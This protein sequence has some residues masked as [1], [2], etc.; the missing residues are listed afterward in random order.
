MA[1]AADPGVLIADEPTTALDV[2]IQ[3]QLL[4]LLKRRQAERHMALILITHDL[5]VVAGTCDRV[6]VMY[7]G[8]IVEE[9]STETVLSSP[10]HPYT[11]GL[12]RSVP[13]LD[14]QVLDRLPSIAGAPPLPG[15]LP[16]GCPF[17]PRCRFAFERCQ[18]D[19][20]LR[21][22]DVEGQAAACWADLRG[23]RV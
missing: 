7:A 14:A 3:A 8:R 10:R 20:P 22:V 13:R 2:T 15:A 23:E 21:P 19:P 12:L 18:A 17:R 1:L 4:E 16:D 11:L 6:A 5:G 9:G